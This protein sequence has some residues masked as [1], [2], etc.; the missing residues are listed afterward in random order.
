[1]KK[2][3]EICFLL[4]LLFS[5]QA[6]ITDPIVQQAQT[7]T[8]EA[9]FD[10]WDPSKL[11]V[12]GLNLVT[13]TDGDR[14]TS[15]PYYK[16]ND[17]YPIKFQIVSGTTETGSVDP[18]LYSVKLEVSA[19]SG[20]S[21]VTLPAA[22]ALPAT[23]GSEGS[24]DWAIP[25]AQPE[26]V[27]YLIRATA[28]NAAGKVFE[29]RSSRTFTIDGGPP[30]INFFG[31][32]PNSLGVVSVGS[33]SDPTVAKVV[34]RSFFETRVA[35][36]DTTTV[37]KFI[38]V[39]AFD[40]NQPAVDD[41][42]WQDLE[43][44][45]ATQVVK[46]DISTFVGFVQNTYKIS[47]WA[48]DY[49]GNISGLT[50]G[51]GQENKDQVTI[52]YNP[53]VAPTITN[54][55]A[56]TNDSS[57]LSPSKEQ[58]TFVANQD[59]F[60]RWKV[61][62]TDLLTAPISLYYT[63]DE[64]NFTE[65]SQMQNITNT[66]VGCTIDT[67]FTGCRRIPAPSSDYFKIQIKVKD[68]SGLVSLSATSALNTAKFSIVAGNTDLGIN[69]SANKAIFLSQVRAADVPG[70][71]GTLAVT[72]KGKV[73]YMDYTRGVLLVDP[74]DGVQKVFVKKGTTKTGDGGQV[75][76][77]TTIGNGKITVDYQDR[78]L[79][80]DGDR[81]RRVEDDGRINTIV[82]GGTVTSYTKAVA[83]KSLKFSTTMNMY[84]LF[85]VL[86]NGNIWFTIGAPTAKVTDYMIGIY[87]A[88]EDKVYFMKLSGKGVYGDP[89]YNFTTDYI[90]TIALSFN[91]RTSQP[92]FLVS[93]ICF[94]IPGG[95]KHKVA[96]F[97]ARNGVAVGYGT[98]APNYAYWETQM[99]ASRRGAI[100]WLGA[101]YPFKLGKYNVATN[102]WNTV[103]GGQTQGYCPDGSVA[104]SCAISGIDAFVDGTNTVYF[105]DAG[106]IRVILP[107]GKVKTLF[108]ERKSAGDGASPLAARMND[109][110][111]MGVWGASDTVV[112][113]DNKEFNVR[114]I[115]Q[116]D[117]GQVRRLAGNY[118]DES[119]SFEPASVNRYSTNVA[120]ASSFANEFWGGIQGVQVDPRDGTFYASL[121]RNGVVVKYERNM[122]TGK[123]NKWKLVLG[124]GGT[125]FLSN[126]ANGVEGRNISMNGYPL[127]LHGIMV[128]DGSAIGQYA[129][130]NGTS[131]AYLVAWTQ[132]FN[133]TCHADP[134]AKIFSSTS[135][136]VR[137]FMGAPT[138]PI[139]VGSNV[140]QEGVDIS[141]SIQMPFW[142]NQ[143][144]SS[145]Y[146]K[147][148]R[149][150]LMANLN[151]TR[152]VKA[153]LTRDGSDRIT[154][155][156]VSSLFATTAK[157]I[158]AFN[159]KKNASDQYELYYCASDGT[160][161]IK[162]LTTN[163]ETNLPLPTSTTG[164]KFFTCDGRSISWDYNKQQ[165]YFPFRQNGLSGVG[166]Y[167]VTSTGTCP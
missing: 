15:F 39:K 55:I 68:Q 53:A 131:Q 112:A 84:S 120:S 113:A 82:G 100:Y 116:G 45:A 34:N 106:Q 129:V 24:Y 155:A 152:I 47:V 115:T 77:A 31:L 148:E 61:T 3:F 21:W 97:N 23:A 79:I 161:N 164:T 110:N 16:S 130:E 124:A 101:H 149:A 98:H 117:S 6:E 42:C 36:S 71:F 90:R 89:E 145:I 138:D 140:L 67:N 52:A 167:C 122:A 123:A 146:F 64:V 154:G 125:A 13:F 132:R 83:A 159:Y 38:C 73:Y 147:E 88:A 22:G 136:T 25:Q 50:A 85:Q 162:N 1:M 119:V 5:C 30:V 92:E 40:V 157:A 114:E 158:R 144:T 7:P 126:T 99:F 59:L 19:N 32:T 127:V 128:P 43:G 75:A 17:T 63:T 91:Y 105:N 18:G 35:V 54:M 33:V 139:C 26:G 142:G 76:S 81:I 141:S 94:P 2:I 65:I 20:T 62:D 96:N 46:T 14:V 60:I 143:T 163:V 102:Q 58:T 118:T 104:A 133:G 103:V 28:T 4:S 95:C 86:P 37:V 134:F 87:K 108:G 8:G 80:F 137:K 111:Y 51:V 49:A 66:A 121:T 9:D 166:K 70:D 151:G 93:Y 72:S 109:I 56:S 165:V 57:S 27:M 160:L 78:L 11:L 150:L 41:S 29:T 48:M 156:G 69:G 74:L 10:E 153:P 107:D 12:P 135:G 44:S